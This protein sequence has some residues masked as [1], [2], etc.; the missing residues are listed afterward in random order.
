VWQSTWDAYVAIVGYE[1][2]IVLIWSLDQASFVVITY[3]FW[4]IGYGCFWFKV[5][6]CPK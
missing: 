6:L 2:G 3:D 5:K 1:K 4:N